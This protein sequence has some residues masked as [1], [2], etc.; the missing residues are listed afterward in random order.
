MNDAPDLTVYRAVHTGVRRA[1]H[2][3][4]AAVVE[5]DPTDRRRTAALARWWRG[6]AGEVLVH[7]TVEDHHFFPAL[8]DRV[9]SAV[10]LIARTDAD[11]AH[12]DEL[13]AGLTEAFGALRAGG[14]G[15]AAARGRALPLTGELARHMD[16]HLDFEDA[17]IL[18][19]FEAH[20]DGAEYEALDAA[21]TK[22][23]G[24][25]RQLAF[26]VPFVVSAIAPDDLT[27]VLATAP[28]ALRVVYRL[29]RRSHARLTAAALGRSTST[30]Q[31]RRAPRRNADKM[32][33]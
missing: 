3:L 26:S 2:D 4:A 1:A 13:M 5:L 16:E 21:A 12:L 9:P 24:L 31:E 32:P 17:E 27:R 15:A 33:A 10:A 8:V 6:Y 30:G 29:T 28:A 25:N 22:S 23:L 20:F 11:H 14:A 18:P 19:L 7:H